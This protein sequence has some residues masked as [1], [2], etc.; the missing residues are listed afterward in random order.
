MSSYIIDVTGENFNDA[1]LSNSHK[2]PVMVNYWAENAGPCLRLWPVLEKLANDYNGQFL[3]VNVDT[4]K[5]K[6]L[7]HDYGI[8]S[9]PTVKLYINGEVVDQIHG[10]DSPDSFKTMLDKYLARDS[11]KDLA[12]AVAEYQK[13]NKELAF[14]QLNK[15]VFIDPENSRIQ[16][17]FAKLLMKEEAYEQAYKLLEKTPLKNESEEAVVLMT[18][19]LFLSTAQKAP[20]LEELLKQIKDKPDDLAVLFQISSHKM[21]Q[22]D[23]SAAMAILLQIIKLDY[24]WRDGIASLCMRGLFIMLGKE[25][26]V[27]IEYRQKLIDQQS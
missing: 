14:E 12:A 2:G 24:S 6:Q 22:S 19:A 13:G 9:V 17:V 3:L 5:E 23:F 4:S 27:V 25:N 16:L 18:N 20:E 7:A 8:N 15:L 21:M 10:Y 1:V 26:P 11:D